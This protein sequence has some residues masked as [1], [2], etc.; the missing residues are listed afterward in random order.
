MA[1]CRLHRTKGIDFLIEG[2][3]RLQMDREAY[4]LVIVGPDEGE[5]QR[6]KSLARKCGVENFVV[7]AGPL[8]GVD[9]LKAF[10]DA[11]IF[12]STSHFEVTGLNCFEALMCGAPVIVTKNTGQGILIEEAQAGYLVPFGDTASLKS[13]IL[14]VTEDRNEALRRVRAGQKYIRE[15]MDW[16]RKTDELIGVYREI[17]PESDDKAP[18]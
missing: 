16:R 6:L 7:F 9:R 4:R 1:T 14:N 5:L 15:Q 10:V 17:I 12:L 3:S 13:Q 18:G 2:F 8:Y 11:D